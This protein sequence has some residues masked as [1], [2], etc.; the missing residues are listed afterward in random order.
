MVVLIMSRLKK[1]VSE[2]KGITIIEVLLAV[3][4]MA[5]V[6]TPLLGTV[7]A[8]VQN[9]AASK[10]KTEAIAFAENVMGRIKAQKVIYP[11]TGEVRYSTG[12]SGNLIP[13]Y[14]I[15]ADEGSVSENTDTTYNY[16]AQA[17]DNPDLELIADQGT[18]TSDGIVDSAVLK[19]TNSAGLESTIE[20]SDINVNTT[21]LKLVINKSGANCT[22][23]FGNKSGS[24]V[25]RGF[26]PED[27]GKI[28]LKVSYKDD[29]SPSPSERLKIFTYI[30]SDT[31][32]I[33]K[34]YETDNPKDNSG[35]TFINK[36]S[37]DFE[38]I[39]M[40]TYA[41]NYSSEEEPFNQLF[42][43]KVSIKK[44]GSVIYKTSSFVKK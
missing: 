35:V 32:D 23:F 14:E 4:L 18:S 39:Y 37:K 21:Y 40:D 36:G 9:N 38:V 17:A 12:E 33:F 16:D 44:N 34:V 28:K 42:K 7:L 41:F 3:T 2:N 19:Y 29:A 25:A 26:N 5:I 1:L 15:D 8:S 13:Y 31:E 43:I 11:T 10:E 22:F 20:Y 6:I 27:P 30:N 24:E